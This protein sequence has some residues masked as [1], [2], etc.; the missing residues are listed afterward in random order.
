MMTW[1]TRS[2][3]RDFRVQVFRRRVTPRFPDMKE[4]KV[5]SMESIINGNENKPSYRNISPLKS[6]SSYKQYPKPTRKATMGRAL[7][8]GDPAR[9][10]QNAVI[11]AM[12]IPKIKG[13]SVFRPPAR[14]PPVYEK[15]L[16]ELNNAVRGLESY[17]S[18]LM[19]I[20]RTMKNTSQEKPSAELRLKFSENVLK[21]RC[22]WPYG[23]SLISQARRVLEDEQRKEAE[24][25]TARR[26]QVAEYIHKTSWKQDVIRKEFVHHRKMDLDLPFAAEQADDDE[27][28]G[29][30]SETAEVREIL[31]N[32]TKIGGKAADT[33]LTR[34]DYIL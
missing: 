33:F 14:L 26:N 31:S 30:S 4:A 32:A 8:R 23:E 9:T 7:N 11:E 24:E 28:A 3:I 10:L 5:S 34:Y 21:E 29:S 6:L 13:V 16:K 18:R 22:E 19:H 2:S 15:Q 20:E 25:E 1:Q 17:N 12:D 27:E